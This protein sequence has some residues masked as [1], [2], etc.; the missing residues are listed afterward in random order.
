MKSAQ[1]FGHQRL[2]CLVETFFAGIE[3]PMLFNQPAGIAGL[4]ISQDHLTHG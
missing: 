1:N 3:H 2:E 4:Q